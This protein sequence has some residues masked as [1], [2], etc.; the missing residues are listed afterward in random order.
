MVIFPIKMVSTWLLNSQVQ[1]PH[2]LTK[3]DDDQET[4]GPRRPE[5]VTRY[6]TVIAGPGSIVIK[7]GDPGM[8]PGI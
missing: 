6:R 3:P 5:G 4:G 7:T 1:Q 8:I 2:I